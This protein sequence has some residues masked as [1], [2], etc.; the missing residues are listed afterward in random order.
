MR[1][2]NYPVV[3][4]EVQCYETIFKRDKDSSGIDNMTS[5]VDVKQ[6]VTIMTLTMKVKK[7]LISNH[8]A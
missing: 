5:Q 3:F 7:R 4:L 2:S 1:V 6:L 8:G